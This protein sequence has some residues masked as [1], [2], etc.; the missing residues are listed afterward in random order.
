[1]GVTNYFSANGIL[2]GEDGPNGKVDYLTDALGS[3]V[4]TVDRRG[5]VLDSFRY[6]PSGN[7]LSKTGSTSNPSFTWVGSRGYRQT[8]L[9]HSEVYVRARHFG[10]P[11]GRWS[12]VDPSWPVQ[13]AYSYARSAPTSRTDPSGFKPNASGDTVDC[14]PN[15]QA[16]CEKACEEIGCGLRYCEY[17]DLGEGA[18]FE[19][20]CGAVCKTRTSSSGA[21]TSGLNALRKLHNATKC[22]KA[23]RGQVSFFACRC[24]G[25]GEE[26]G[27]HVSYT[28]YCNGGCFK[29]SVSCCPCS[30]GGSNCTYKAGPCQG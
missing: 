13:P 29:V 8:G 23:R 12:S 21:L 9:P 5:Q 4:T 22:G 16:Q 10:S 19:C 2:L 17:F 1:M 26:S 15:I 7:Q 25:V 14:P 11:E 30:N 6:T 27:T 18:A 24:D 3:V 20:A 28:V